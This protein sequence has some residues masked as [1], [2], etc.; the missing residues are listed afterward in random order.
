MIFQKINL[1]FKE[2]DLR[3]QIRDQLKEFTGILV[4]SSMPFNL[5]INHPDATKGNGILRLASILGLKKAQTMAF[6]DGENDLS[7][8]QE[9]EIGVAMENGI[10]SLKEAADYVTLSNDEDGVAAAIEHVILGQR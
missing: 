8:I 3:S 2:P 6:G 5:E 1:F 10:Q 9:A 7:M 4:T